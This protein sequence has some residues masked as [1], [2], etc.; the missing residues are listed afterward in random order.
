MINEL[1]NENIFIKHFNS[2]LAC[3]ERSSNSI[4]IKEEDTKPSLFDRIFY[5]KKKII[6]DER[7]FYKF[8]LDKSNEFLRQQFAPVV[9]NP[10]GTDIQYIECTAI[11]FPI[12]WDFCQFVRYA[13]KVIFYDNK[14]DNSLF[15]DSKLDEL[16]KRSFCITSKDSVKI[17]INLEKVSRP[18]STSSIKVLYIDINRDYGKMMTTQYKIIDGNIDKLDQSD[19]ALIM[20]LNLLIYKEVIHTYISIIEKLIQNVEESIKWSKNTQTD[21]LYLKEI[22]EI[23]SEYV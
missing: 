4:F 23:L 20:N 15:V 7:V 1:Y 3:I 8:V 6:N 21:T 9:D 13:E 18:N 19:T 16:S 12:L 5:K 2:L 22:E 17:T 10:T 14:I 11:S